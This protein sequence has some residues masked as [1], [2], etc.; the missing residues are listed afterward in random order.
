MDGTPPVSTVSDSTLGV[1]L[2]F[3]SPTGLSAGQT[4]RCRAVN[5]GGALGQFWAICPDLR[6]L[7]A[8]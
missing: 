4:P 7:T 6:S 3:P 2:R 1:H 8:Q 5:P